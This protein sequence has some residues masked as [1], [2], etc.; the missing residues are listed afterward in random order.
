MKELNIEYLFEQFQRH[1]SKNLETNRQSLNEI[2]QITA[3]VSQVLADA[4]IKVEPWEFY[5][6]TLI[7]KILLCS[8]SIAKL[9]SGVDLT[10]DTNKKLNIELIDISS[11]FILSRSLI[12][13][14]LTLDYIYI[15]DISEEEKYFRF[16]L[17]EISG[18]ISRQNFSTG[19]ISKLGQKKAKEKVLIEKLKNEIEKHEKFKSL[20]KHQLSK[21]NKFGLPRLDSWN[22]L[23]ESSRLNESYFK[24][25][26]SYFSNY[27][28]S[29]YLSILQLKQSSLKA[30][31]KDNLS[32]ANISLSVVRIINSVIII[33]LKEKFKACEMKYNMFPSDKTQ[34]VE[35]WAKLT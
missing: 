28:H 32:K 18:L 33:W 4:K 31:N 35:M 26:Y 20:S 2:I 27:A 6:E 14:Y 12:E 25:A 24:N 19:E 30:Q 13:C 21:L 11:L 5:F 29:E 9:S 10:S 34:I 17:W 7:H 22:S 23:I 16:K 8:L 3:D 1:F 15:T